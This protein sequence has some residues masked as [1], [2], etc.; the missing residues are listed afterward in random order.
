VRAAQEE[1]AAARYINDC[2]NPARY[3]VAFEKRPGAAPGPV[4]A[5]LVAGSPVRL[6][7]QGRDTHQGSPV[8]LER[9]GRDTH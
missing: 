7:R 4:P 9:Q 1:G 8:R 5:P 6:E 3:N 2:R